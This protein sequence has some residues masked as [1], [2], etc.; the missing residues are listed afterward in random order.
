MLVLL[1]VLLLLLLLLLLGDCEC[2]R[3]A[4][5]HNP[6]G[7]PHTARGAPSMRQALKRT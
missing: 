7:W 2:R 3:G 6:K 5:V 4:G 1:L